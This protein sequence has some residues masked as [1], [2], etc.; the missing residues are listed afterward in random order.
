MRSIVAIA[1]AVVAVLCRW[2]PAASALPSQYELPQYDLG[3]FTGE[4]PRDWRLVGNRCFR[5]EAT[6][7]AAWESAVAA[8]AAPR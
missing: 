8:C 3:T 5:F 2:T 6:R 4:C 1:V 7:V